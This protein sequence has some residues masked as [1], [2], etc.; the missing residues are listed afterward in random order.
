MEDVKYSSKH[1]MLISIIPWNMD[2]IVVCP[3]T[4]TRKSVVDWLGN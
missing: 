3:A 2:S 4:P 1:F